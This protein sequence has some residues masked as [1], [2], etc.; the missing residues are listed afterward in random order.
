MYEPVPPIFLTERPGSFRERGVMAPFTTPSLF[1]SRIRLD[2]RG[3]FEVLQANPVGG[4][5]C[6]IV[7]L[8]GLREVTVPTVH[9]RWLAEW[10]LGLKRLLPSLVRRLA[11][12]AAMLGLAGPRAL[13]AARRQETEERR[14]QARIR[15]AWL[16]RLHP[17]GGAEEEA[18]AALSGRLGVGA[19]WLGRGLDELAHIG[20]LLGAD[21]ETAEEG[22]A[23][24]ALLSLA[25]LRD[26]LRAWAR[27]RQDQEVTMLAALLAYFTEVVL[28]EAGRTLAEAQHLLASPGA[29]L[30]RLAG[31]PEKLLERLRRTEWVLDGWDLLLGLWQQAGT[32]KA[33]RRA[34]REMIRIAPP[35]PRD[36]LGDRVWPEEIEALAATLPPLMKQGEP[37][38]EIPA[39]DLVARNEGLLRHEFNETC[40]VHAA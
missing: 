29:L 24:R 1:G 4:L 37:L 16:S 20:A 17:A 40:T 9:D 27:R 28:E 39:I 33:Q 2:E 34:L 38:E 13:V 12:R 25:D 8:K 36:L 26:D 11:R 3:R 32:R 30:E 21:E 14:L 10:L 5:G 22:F 18:L 15:R 31:E 23:R 6:Y 19:A 7:P 35:L